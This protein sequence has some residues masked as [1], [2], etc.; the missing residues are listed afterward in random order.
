MQIDATKSAKINSIFPEKRVPDNASLPHFA[1]AVRD[2][3]L[4][5]P[6]ERRTPEYPRTLLA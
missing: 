6:M 3:A 5:I 1:L 2:A 4:E